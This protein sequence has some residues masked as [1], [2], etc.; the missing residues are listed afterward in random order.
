MWSTPKLDQ[1]AYLDQCFHDLIKHCRHAAPGAQLPLQLQMRLEKLTIEQRKQIVNRPY[2]GCSSLFIACKRGNT[3]I[4]EYLI[5]H[6]H[7]DI[8]MKG[9]YE[10]ADDHSIH[11]VTPLWCASVCGKIDV[12]KC[13]VKHGGDVN[14]LSDTGSTPVRSACFMANLEIVKFLT[15]HGANIQKTNYNGGTCLINAIQSVPLC[16]F[17]LENGVDVNAQDIQLKTALH[18]AIQDHRI[19]TTMLLLKH[20]ADPFIKN[21]YGDDALQIA[22]LKG[23]GNIFRHLISNLHYSKERIAEAYELLGSTYLDESFNVHLVMDCWG[24]ALEIRF[25]DPENPIP[26]KLL[27]PNPAYMNA[28]EFTTFEELEAISHDLD[29]MRMQSLLIIERI[30]SSTHKEVIYRLM[31]RGATYADAL[32]YQ[33]CI[34][35]WKYSFILRIRKDTL[36]HNEAAF[37][38]HALV[39]LFLDLNEK[40]SMGLV[41]DELRYVDLYET[42]ELI[43]DQL[44]TC[45]ELL[46]IRPVFKK[47]QENFD[48]ILKILTYL[49]SILDKNSRTSKQQ[50]QTYMLLDRIC[51]IAPYTSNG[52]SLLHLV[53]S[54]TNVLKS[55][56]NGFEEIYPTVFPC[57]KMCQLLLKAG[58]D[59]NRVNYSGETPLHIATCHQNFNSKI[60]ELL[61]KEGAH[62]DQKDLTG[63]QPCRRLA[64]INKCN[65][66]PL[67]Y[68]TLQCLASS[69]IK[70]Y[71][72]D[73]RGTV[74]KEIQ[75]FIDLH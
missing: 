12:V 27:P 22:C 3:E 62:I 33:R 58:F 17:L 14:S 6:C 41:R 13:L 16:E 48:R 60:V 28:Q 52:D 30:L 10:V 5:E 53:V 11:Y 64:A 51:Q 18:Y 69:K 63:N 2:E 66:N 1:S 42:I 71:N 70:S 31:Y 21:R 45:Q 34:D 15:E 7:A 59:V 44:S 46:K 74:P 36:L 47:H 40:I 67:Q 20:G 50:N 35:L 65:I 75:N 49:I 4:V 73:Y 19:E 37:A 8:E 26:K 43:V 25:S 57:L 61:L 39:R 72:L 29:A 68:L 54:K 24:K 23:D 32:Q 56:T 9:I 38:S 55:Q